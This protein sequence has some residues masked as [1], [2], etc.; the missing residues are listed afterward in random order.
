[1]KIVT[2]TNATIGISSPADCLTKLYSAHVV[3]WLRGLVV[4]EYGVVSVR[5]GKTLL[6][7]AE[8]EF[9]IIDNDNL[10]SVYFESKRKAVEFLIALH[11]RELAA[12]ENKVA[13]VEARLKAA[14]DWEDEQPC[15]S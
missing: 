9:T 13:E 8:G 12:L 14:R 4:R 3:L 11:E 5:G 2:P 7:T 15:N 6:I 1:M 10:S